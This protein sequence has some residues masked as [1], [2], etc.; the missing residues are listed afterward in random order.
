MN[1]VS[2]TATCPM[3]KPSSIDAR[4]INSPMDSLKSGIWPRSVPLW[5]AGVYVALFIIRPWEELFPWLGDL[6][7]ERV[8][9]LCMIASV[10][11]SKKRHFEMSFQALTVVLFVLSMGLSAVFAFNTSLAGDAFLEYLKLIVF[12][13][14][15]IMVV[16]TPYQLVFIVTCYIAA[17]TAYL[18]K[19][20]W[21]FFFHGQNRYDMGVYRLIGIESTFGGPN[22]LAMSIVVSLPMLLFLWTVRKEFSSEWPR[23]ARKWFPILLASYFILAISSI[24]LT[25]SR[26]GMLSMILFVALV[27]IGRKGVF[28][29]S[30]YF[31][32]GGLMLLTIWHLAP[33]DNRERFMTIWNPEAGPENARVSADGRIEGYKAGMIMFDRF[34]ITGV[35]VG[36]FITYRVVYVDGI[37]LEAHNLAGELLGETGVVGGISFALMVLVTL[38]NC[39][40]VRTIARKNR[41][42]PAIGVLSG[43]GKACRNAVILLAFEGLFGH[44]LLRFNWLWLAAF[45]ILALQSARMSMKTRGKV[46]NNDH[47]QVVL[48]GFRKRSH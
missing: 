46:L 37:A 1:L 36:N 26:S 17:M 35:G 5:M 10:A 9:A 8:Y 42:D 7:F 3:K 19:S 41:F 40:K 24:I 15:L 30:A 11:L 27:I 18:A 14:V 20:Q 33:E 2:S 34:P 4:G 28:R 13:F 48:Q 25:N 22:S 31:L 47:S 21:E 6:R 23:L 32:L 29:K 45:S 16:R 12:Y 43:L 39:Y 38:V 44:N